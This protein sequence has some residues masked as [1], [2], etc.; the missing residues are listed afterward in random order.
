MISEYPNLTEIME[1]GYVTGKHSA[2]EKRLA[3]G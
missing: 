3:A 1:I 2:K